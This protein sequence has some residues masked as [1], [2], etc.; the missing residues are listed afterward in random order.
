MRPARASRRCRIPL[1]AL[2]TPLGGGLASIERLAVVGEL[3][4]ESI[5]LSQTEMVA[6]FA[7]PCWTASRNNSSRKRPIANSASS[8][9]PKALR[10]ARQPLQASEAAA[11]VP[12][13]SREQVAA[14]ARSSFWHK[15]A[16]APVVYLQAIIIGINAGDLAEAG[17]SQD[18]FDVPVDPQTAIS[19]PRRMSVLALHQ[20]ANA[21]RREEGDFGEV[22]N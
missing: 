3:D 19:A 8:P 14:E 10:L 4:D 15:K 6:W 9:M 13:N 16:V 21:E 11:T 20:S 22:D 2:L 17:R 1:S 5:G 12:G 7:W 18:L